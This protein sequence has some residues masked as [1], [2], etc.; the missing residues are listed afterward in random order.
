MDKQVSGILRLKN[1]HIDRRKWDDC[2]NQAPNSR[3]YALSWYLDIVCHNWEGLVYGDYEYVLPLTITRKMG[4]EFLLRAPFCQQLGIFPMADVKITQQFMSEIEKFSFVKYAV[5]SYWIMPKETGQNL[6]E[7]PNFILPLYVGYNKL[8]KYFTSHCKRHIRKTE[9]HQIHVTTSSDIIRFVQNT[10]KYSQYPINKKSILCLQQI[11]SR[12]IYQGTGQIHSAFDSQ[13]NLCASV[14]W[15]RH[16]NRIYYL[17]AYSTAE[18]KQ[19]SAMYALVNEM[20]NQNAETGYVIDFEGSQ[21]DGIAR[22]YKG[23]GAVNENYFSIESNNLPWIIKL[24]CKAK[25]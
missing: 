3:V 7:L 12:A 23:F 24:L 25:L 2:I 16:K 8:Q 18:G 21:I 6:K 11:I 17:S 15:L 19:K 1:S 9:K 14:F 20:I 22:F 4:V 13:N 10:L 5:N